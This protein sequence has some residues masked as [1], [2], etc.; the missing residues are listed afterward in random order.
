MVA[1][2]LVLGAQWPDVEV[3]AWLLLAALATAAC[4]LAAW[5]LPARALVAL[6]SIVGT[7]VGLGLA[8]IATVTGRWIVTA[9]TCLSTVFLALGVAGWLKLIPPDDAAAPRL[10]RK[11]RRSALAARS[12]RG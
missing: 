8:D 9:G 7:T 6:A 2:G 1:L 4:A 12:G 3:D 10:A 5:R 11:A